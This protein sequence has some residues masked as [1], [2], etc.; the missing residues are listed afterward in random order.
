[1]VF[2]DRLQAS[3]TCVAVCLVTALACGALDAQVTGVVDVSV[4]SAGSGEPVAWA[5]ITVTEG[6]H[7]VADDRGR[8]RLRGVRPGRHTLTVE[9]FGHALRSVEVTVENGR[10]LRL[11]V[12]LT[13][14]AFELDPLTVR[15]EASSAVDAVVLRPEDVGP[16]VRD[17]ADLLE[18]VPGAVIVRR[19][20][21]GAPVSV[22]LRGADADQVLVLLDGVPMNPGGSGAVDLSLIDLD[23]LERV[24]VLPGARS[25][26]YG[27]GALGGVI[28]L[29]SGGHRGRSVE[30]AAALGAWGERELS[31][32]VSTSIG[33]GGRAT[34]GGGWHRS[35]GAFD[36]AVPA[37]RGGGIAAR[38]NAHSE[39]TNGHLTLRLDRPGRRLA[40]RADASLGERGSPG[41]VAQPSLTGE[42]THH[43]IG[44]SLSGDVGGGERGASARIGLLDRHAE[45]RDPSPPFGQAYDDFSDVTHVEAAAEGWARRG[46]FDVRGGVEG[47]Q[48]RV[49][50]TALG[51]DGVQYDEAGAWVETAASLAV[52]GSGTVGVSAALRADHH[53]LVDDVVLSPTASVEYRNPSVT[54]T[55]RHAWGFAPPSVSDLFF[56]EGVL[57]R[58]NPELRPERVRG[59]WTVSASAARAVGGVALRI[60]G[61][62]WQADVEDMILWFPDFR[63][64]WSP[65]N[66]LVTRRGVEGGL[67]ADFRTGP[68]RHS[69]SG[70]GE[71]SLVEYADG[72][73]E[74]QVGYRPRST[75]S[76]SLRTEAPFGTLTADL[77]RI[78]VRRSVPGS[79]LNAL[80]AWD[81]IDVGVGVPFDLGSADAR[82]DVSV[83][84]LLDSSAALL[85]DFPLPGRG[86]AVRLRLF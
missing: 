67:T 25:A 51:A 13:P 75:A 42:Q 30:A 84:N 35:D 1:M 54:L 11:D 73:L 82:V 41:A 38:E 86:W 65:D 2:I 19:G 10:I 49:E 58:A 18:T 44:A 21:P 26:R 68:L 12:A 71:L 55:V 80:P 77:S 33:E 79:D 31:A 62:A 7:V 5:T 28:L 59:E 60:E 24:V 6:E 23:R 76:F 64:I 53:E 16:A 57:V 52:G 78:G 43:R 14:L 61:S 29:E 56:E 37:F 69:L 83:T 48:L 74:G 17:V 3:A 50:A 32:T 9:A 72:G 15:G 45:Y 81:E 22:Q 70:R 27:A 40:L 39:R 4:T 85:A 46:I 36:Y 47:R 8:A 66:Y 63:F 20:G 34:A